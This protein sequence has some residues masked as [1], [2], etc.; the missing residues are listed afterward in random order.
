MSGPAMYFSVDG[1]ELLA[2][3]LEMALGQCGRCSVDTFPF[4]CFSKQIGMAI[5]K[6]SHLWRYV[7]LDGISPIQLPDGA[8]SLWTY[9]TY[10]A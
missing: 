7:S 4:L 9:C 2:C 10:E 3:T 1:N 6:H 8:C 5:T